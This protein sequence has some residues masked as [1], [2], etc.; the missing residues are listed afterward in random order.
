MIMAKNDMGAMGCGAGGGNR[1]ASDHISTQHAMADA[2]SMMSKPQQSV[3]PVSSK[4]KPKKAPSNA[5]SLTTGTTG[6]RN[7]PHPL[8]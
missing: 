4:V 1:V 5:G 7:F 8:D 3:S 2:S 6:K